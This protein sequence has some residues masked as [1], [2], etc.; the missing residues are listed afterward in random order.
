[1]NE[2]P[3][4]S[5]ASGSEDHSHS[6]TEVSTTR[7]GPD[8]PAPDRID[9]PS[10]PGGRHA[11]HVLARRVR[12]FVRAALVGLVAGLAGV[13]F[14]ESLFWAERTRE[15]LLE[16]LRRHPAWGWAALPVIGLF[17]G[18]LVGWC[19]RRFAPDAPG[20]G[21][22]HVKGV[23]IRVRRM[24][25]RKLLPVKFLGG[26]L[27]IGA[28]L[29]LGRE[30]PTVQL[31]AAVG[32]ALGD[33]LR[34]PQRTLPQLISCGAGAG[35]A[36][37]F[38]A[39]LAGFLFVLEELHREL[40]ALTYGGALI[41]AV[42]ATIVTEAVTGQAPS[43]FVRTV[44]TLPLASLPLVA[45]L[46]VAAGLAGVL[47]N[48]ALVESLRLADRLRLRWHWM[49]PGLAAGVVGLAAWWLPDAVGGG[50]GAAERLL[51]GHMS[52]TT[53]TLAVL[54]VAK[55][56]LTVL[57]YASGAPGG[58]F[59]PMLLLGAV[60]GALVGKAA[61]TIAPAPAPNEAA[62]AVLGMAAFF[63]ASVRAPLTGIVLILEM[64]AMQEQLFALCVVCLVA[65]L[66]AERLGDRPIYDALLELDLLRRGA[67]ER[68]AE[69]NQVV[70]SIFLG[71]KVAG[72]RI[73]SAGFPRGG[74]IVGVERSGRELLPEADLELAPGDHI[75]VVTPGHE[76]RLA[77][78][79]VRLCRDT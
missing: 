42:C 14:R 64:T 73:R 29:S 77:M 68:R 9:W 41:A 45:L 27:G 5:A 26:V 16:T 75:T 40:S 61:G 12:H 58:I 59:A 34:V 51:N 79:V 32:N 13:A 53:A 1:M 70:V 4:Q 24:D 25:W 48:K 28:G 21:I 66:V 46:G 74:L 36:A 49:L 22:P 54:F 65:Y 67:L 18:G 15:Q 55:L 2:E 50:H 62:F 71:S 37:A 35:L 47:F 17:I 39:P 11:R 30:G 19:V 8:A 20:S 10:A 69:P 78:E 31:G 7:P 23:L 72:K 6:E 44:S 56:A 63:A 3:G 76:P 43:F 57:S 52:A 33:L 38:N 60:L